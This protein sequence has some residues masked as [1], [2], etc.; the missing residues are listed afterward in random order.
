MSFPMSLRMLAASLSTDPASA[1]ALA[2]MELKSPPGLRPPSRPVDVEAADVVVAVA[3]ADDD[4]S[5]EAMF[6]R[7][8]WPSVLVLNMMTW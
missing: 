7:K 8:F 5:P 2:S 4:E 3:V 1:V 6:S